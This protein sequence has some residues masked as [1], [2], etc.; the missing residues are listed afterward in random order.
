MVYFFE[1]RGLR[2]SRTAHQ[3]RFPGRK[4]V[5]K[6]VFP[7]YFLAGHIA[8]AYPVSFLTVY[9]PVLLLHPTV[10]DV[11]VFQAYNLVRWQ[12]P[13]SHLP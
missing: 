11:I 9:L 12:T 8:T 1:S 3:P 5:G 4:Y 2:Y 10:C 7:T 6:A 13:D